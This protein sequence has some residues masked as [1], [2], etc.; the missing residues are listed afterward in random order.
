MF[1][2]LD[3]DEKIVEEILNQHGTTLEEFIT[4]AHKH[5]ISKAE[6]DWIYLIH[7]MHPADNPL[8]TE[9]LHHCYMFEKK[10]LKGKKFEQI[11]VMDNGVILHAIKIKD[12]EKSPSVLYD[13]L[14]NSFKVVVKEVDKKK[15]AVITG[16]EKLSKV[17]WSG[18][19]K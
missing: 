13:H 19:D 10:N 4:G 6:Q 14:N 5:K 2:N 3:L 1:I 12:P 7:H 16:P 9:I 17:K 11:H 15:Y 8:D 18:Q